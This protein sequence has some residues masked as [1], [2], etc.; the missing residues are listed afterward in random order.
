MEEEIKEKHFKSQPGSLS[1]PDSREHSSLSE[2]KSSEYSISMRDRESNLYR[3][4]NFPAGLISPPEWRYS[5]N[6]YEP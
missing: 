3:K 6:K 4:M 2:S 5:Q 1:D